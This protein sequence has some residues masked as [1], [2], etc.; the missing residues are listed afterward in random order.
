MRDRLARCV[1]AMALV[2]TSLGA[3][4]V[5]PG[6]ATASDAWPATVNARYRLKFQGIEVGKSD[7]QSVA[8]A[9]G[10]TLSGTSKLSVLLGAFKIQTSGNATGAIGG[11]K[12]PPTLAP[13]SF[14]FD[15][16]GG[17]KK[18]ATRMGFDGGLAKPSSIEPPIEP[19]PDRVPLTE[20]HYRDVVDP[21]TAIMVLTRNDGKPCDKRVPI[22]DGK[23]RFD[24]A[25][26]YK[27]QE[28]IPHHGKRAN[29]ATPEMGVVCRVTYTPIAGHKKRPETDSFA[30]NK[31]IEVLLRRVPGSD[32]MIPYTVTIPTGWGTATMIAE[33]VEVTSTKIGRV[34]W[35]E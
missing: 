32:M 33:K 29:A 13:K 22:F 10:Y 6:S 27:R 31:D 17:S 8:T 4:A 24:V 16:Q 11:G 5:A 30:A 21:I 34:A 19:H 23:H 9:T 14:V 1:S 18:G 25:F 2:A 15:W 12:S 26:S 20:A 3:A 7:I 28:A 35:S